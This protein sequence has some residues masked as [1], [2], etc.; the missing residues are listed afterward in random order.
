M[1]AYA[2]VM[3]ARARASS[4]RRA[5]KTELFE[6]MEK[7]G[8]ER[9]TSAIWARALMKDSW[10]SKLVAARSRRSAPASRRR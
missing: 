7:R 10:R 1:E 3:E 9:W 8:R 2:A 6:I 4:P 5:S